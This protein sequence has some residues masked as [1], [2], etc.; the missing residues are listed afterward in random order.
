MHEL[1]LSANTNFDSADGK[2]CFSSMF[3]VQLAVNQRHNS[4]MGLQI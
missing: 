4:L 1:L 2:D 3:Y